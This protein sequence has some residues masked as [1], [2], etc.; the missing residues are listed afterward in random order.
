MYAT[1]EFILI[2]M[3]DQGESALLCLMLVIIY[4]LGEGDDFHVANNNKY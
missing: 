3:I 2:R 1:V 4:T